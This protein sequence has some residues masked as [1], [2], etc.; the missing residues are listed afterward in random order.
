MASYVFVF[1]NCDAEKSESSMNIFYNDEVYKN[2]LI[3]RRR[4]L[5]KINS[6]RLAGRVKIAEENLAKVERLI[7]EGNPLDASKFIQFGAIKALKCI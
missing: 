3:S 7:L 5:A 2:T 4:L 1:F 6:E